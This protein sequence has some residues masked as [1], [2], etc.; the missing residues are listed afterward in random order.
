MTENS[1]ANLIPLWQTMRQD[2]VTC[3]VTP[4]LDYIGA[5][6]L[7]TLDARYAG[8][9]A[10][11]GLGEGLRQLLGGLEDGAILHFL[12]RAELGT[13]EE[14]IREYERLCV[15]E[16]AQ[17][18]LTAYVTG[19]ASWLRQQPL[20]KTRLF[21]FFSKSTLKVTAGRRG[22]LGAPLIFASSSGFTEKDHRARVQALGELRDR[23]VARLAP[24]GIR[25]RE[26]TL[27]EVW[28]LHFK[29]LNPNRSKSHI[30]PR[31]PQLDNLL[32]DDTIKQLGRHVAEYTEAEQLF[33]EDLEEV[34]DENGSA[35]GCLRQGATFRRVTTLKILPEGGTN[36]YGVES[37]L[38]DL[39]EDDKP[40]PYTLAVTVAIKHQGTARWALSQRHE[41][42]SQLKALLP[43]LSRQSV[44]QEEAE[45]AQQDSIRALFT[46]LNELSTKIASLSVSLLLEAP[47]LEALARRTEAARAAFAAAGN[48]QMQDETWTQV[49]AFLSV[50][51]TSGPYQLRKKGCTSRNAAD[52]LPVFG[53]WPG[54]AR[55]ASLLQTPGGDIFRFDP[56]DRKIVNAHHG[57][58]VADT[59]SGKSFT[60]GAILLDALGSGVEGVL[61][62]NGGSWKALTELLGGVH[63]PVDLSTSISPFVSYEEMLDPATR[64]I[65]NEDLEMAVNFIEVC[66]QDRTR[67]AFDKVE[68]D[69]VSKAIRWCYETRFRDRPTERPLIGHFVDALKAFNWTHPDD[70]RIAEDLCR[71][72]EIFRTGI[73]RDL[74]NKPS[75]L[76][77]DVPL[78][79][80]EMSKVAEN[81]TTRAIAMATMIQAISNRAQRRQRPTIVA[82][83][84]AHEYIGADEATGAFLGRSWRKMRKFGTAMYA[85][86]QKLPDFLTNHNAREAILGNSTLRYFLRHLKGN[87]GPVVEHFQLPPRAAKAFE[88]LSMK[89]GH[90]ADLM[91]MY[92]PHTSVLRLAVTPLAYWILTTDKQDKDLLARARQKNPLLDPL[93]L[94]RELAARYPNGVVG[95]STN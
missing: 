44:A 54:A 19:R 42:V 30:P 95:A 11:A 18:A 22:L 65:S 82:I 47:S 58:V 72:L 33:N 43:F 13:A 21:L 37:F 66:V 45:R 56:F 73:Y 83:D 59:G 60:M 94:L 28:R 78:L 5:L 90:Y 81:P 41:L 1:L 26:L 74:L 20:R 7:G 48:S 69:A 51:P 63:V 27:D 87:H 34:Q 70:K 75:T 80:F 36:Y 67:L 76:K 40:F 14:D 8:E 17:P 71:R 93:S 86:T 84:E 68:K 88:N 57:I 50:L 9:E 38:E 29:L 85:I 6:E 15:R 89:P 10:I 91:L 25:S 53:P 46:E 49:P 39:R 3:L 32:D 77:F 92:G 62:D 61:V 35:L 24:V 55:A 23:I 52:L 2:G 64:E 12:Y 79:T 4:A 31:P 16:G